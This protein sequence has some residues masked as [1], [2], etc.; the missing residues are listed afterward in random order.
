[1]NKWPVPA[2]NSSLSVRLHPVISYAYIFISDDLLLTLCH[3][4]FNFEHVWIRVK[5]NLK[6]EKWLVVQSC[7]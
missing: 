3:T 2:T 1:M 6:N 4:M 5:Q 7:E